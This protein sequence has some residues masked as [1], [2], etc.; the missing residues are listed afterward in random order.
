LIEET[1]GIPEMGKDLLFYY[2][3]LEKGK[4]QRQKSRSLSQKP[5]GAD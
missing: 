3:K 2:K 5:G 1:Q 4:K